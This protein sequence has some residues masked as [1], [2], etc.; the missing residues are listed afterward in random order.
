MTKPSSDSSNQNKAP[1][2]I[3]KST[4]SLS[5]SSVTSS[6]ASLSPSTSILFSAATNRSSAPTSSSNR[7]SSY[8]QGQS[9]NPPISSSSSIST[10][11]ATRNAKLESI[12]QNLYTKTAQ[13]I[14]QARVPSTKNTSGKNKLNKWF[15][16]TTN[17]NEKLKEELKFWK[18]LIKYQQDAEEP[19][20]LVIDIYLET[21]EPQLLQEGDDNRGWHRL[22]FGIQ[23]NDIQRI[24]IESWTLSLNHPLPDY[25][26]DLPNLYKRSIVFFRSLHSLVRILPSHSLFERLRLREGEISLGYR[27]STTRSNRKDEISLDHALTSSDTIQLHEFKELSTPLG[28]FKLKLLFREHCQFDTKEESKL[29]G[30]DVDEH[31]FTPTMTKYRLENSKEKAAPPPS[32]VPLFSTAASTASGK[33]RLKP[34]RGAATATTTANRTAYYLTNTGS[35]S[36]SVS[37]NNNS[38]ASQLERRI[39]APLVSPFKSPSLSSSPQAELM[40]N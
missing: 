25:P 40:C 36:S 30:I 33:S 14:I 16:I 12:I 9:S 31:F 6:T 29:D 39:S 19:Q 11:S 10:S 35:S 17:D 1:D 37:S 8:R 3:T 32:P 38:N 24:L 7:N 2:P 34:S 18:S 27:L 5:K 23:Q 22:D 28:T 13:T 21:S 4:G 20:P 26:V 15:N